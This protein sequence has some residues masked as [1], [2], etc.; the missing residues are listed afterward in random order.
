VEV[1]VDYSENFLRGVSNGF[2]DFVYIDASHRYE[3]TLN[4]LHLAYP[5]VKKGGFLFGDDYDPDTASRQHG[6]YRAVNE[7]AIE[8]KLALIL[9][10]T[11]QWGLRA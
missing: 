5:K 10:Q 2:F 8:Q 3:A 1:I 11:R 6:V 4:E 7:F 9:N